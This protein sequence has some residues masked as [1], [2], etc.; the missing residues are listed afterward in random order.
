MVINEN[1]YIVARQKWEDG[2]KMF[3]SK[4]DLNYSADQLELDYFSSMTPLHPKEVQT[5][6]ECALR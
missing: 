6:I 4:E 1:T 3:F 5:E 2:N